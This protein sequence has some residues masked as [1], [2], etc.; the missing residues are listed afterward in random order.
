MGGKLATA[1]K[2]K[3]ADKRKRSLAQPPQQ[4][5]QQQQLTQLK[6]NV[7]SKKKVRILKDG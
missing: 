6:V 4:Q 3:H 2:L 1:E 7:M 5:Q